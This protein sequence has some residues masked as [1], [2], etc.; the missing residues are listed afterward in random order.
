MKKAIVFAV[1]VLFS[2][3]NLGTLSAAEWLDGTGGAI[4]YN[5]GNVGIGINAPETKFH[6]VF[7]ESGGIIAQSSTLGGETNYFEPKY[8]TLTVYRGSST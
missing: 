7:T 4:Y 2:L 8:P 6:V 3:V 1:S 5:D